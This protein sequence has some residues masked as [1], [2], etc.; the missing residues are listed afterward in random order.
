LYEIS[1]YVFTSVGGVES[2]KTPD[3][4]K[5]LQHVDEMIQTSVQA[6]LAKYSYRCSSDG[7]RKYLTS[8]LELL[9]LLKQL[10]CN[11][12]EIRR[13][14]DHMTW[15]NVSGTQ[16]YPGMVLNR[17]EGTLS[18]MGTEHTFAPFPREVSARSLRPSSY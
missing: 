1:E 8:W 7:D 5:Y 12:D 10:G 11:V 15:F 18:F 16:T 14:M 17:Y 3:T 4:E 13:I 2:I 6:T 9:I